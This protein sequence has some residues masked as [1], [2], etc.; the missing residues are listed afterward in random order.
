[1]HQLCERYG[2]HYASV[3][4]AL[5]SSLYTS[6]VSVMELTKDQLC[7]RYGTHYKIVM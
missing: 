1:M 6:Y 3:M 7:E 2:A 5:W 4:S